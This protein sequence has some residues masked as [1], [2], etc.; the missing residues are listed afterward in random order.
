MT[1]HRTSTYGHGKCILAGEHGVL[2]GVPAVVWPLPTYGVSG[3][4]VSGASRIEAQTPAGEEIVLKEADSLREFYQTVFEKDM[5]GVRLKIQIPL[6]MGLGGSA[7]ISVALARLWAPR[8]V[9]RLAHQLEHIFHGASSGLDVVGAMAEGPVFYQ[10]ASGLREPLVLS[11][12]P[13]LYLSSTGLQSSTREAVSQVMRLRD[14][15]LSFSQE[16]DEDMGRATALVR[17]GLEDSKGLQSLA[18]GLRLARGCFEA[19]GL[20]TEGM[21]AS[22]ALLENLGAVAVKPTGAGLGGYL[23]S[24]WENPPPED[25]PLIPLG[26][27]E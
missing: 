21:A 15:D 26:R 8:D 9:F 25:L 17:A 14:E 12:R 1:V 27:P 23:L 13:F 16:L 22:M 6:G 7:A 20:V 5:P 3:E 4:L 19:W 11:W 2:R 24:L 18:Q 10:M